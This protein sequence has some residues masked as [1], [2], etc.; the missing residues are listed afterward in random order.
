[1]KMEIGARVGA[2]ESATASE[3]RMFGYGVYDGDHDPGCG[4]MGMSGEEWAQSFRD[5]GMEPEPWLNPRITL[6]NGKV[7]W[8]FQCWWGAEESVKKAVGDRKV[9][10][11]DPPEIGK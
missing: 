9:L 3:V 6:D 1:M 11:V 7:A 5:Q 8:G 4:P 2:M 10:Y